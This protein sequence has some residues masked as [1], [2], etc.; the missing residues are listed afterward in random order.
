M[1]V[2]AVAVAYWAG[3]PVDAAAYN[4][5]AEDHVACALTYPSGTVYDPDR[6]AHN[7]A[8][9]FEH[10]VDI[11]GRS[12]GVYHVIDAHMCPYKGRNYAHV[13]IRGNGQTLS[14]FA[15]RAERGALPDT[16]TT[17]LAG[18]ALDVHATTRLGY[19][20]SAVATRDH[21]LFLVSERPTDPPDLVQD[22]LRSAVRFI[23]GLEK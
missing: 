20:I 10:I 21:R 11:V 16:P 7:L 8:P 9:P 17:V 22:I 6:A 15:E 18:D 12:H 19:R 5:S 3:R 1:L 13:V 23:R 2:A 4:D 14:L